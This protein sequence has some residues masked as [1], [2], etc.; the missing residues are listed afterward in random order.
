MFRKTQLQSECEAA[1]FKKQLAHLISCGGFTQ[2]NFGFSIQ[3]NRE[4]THYVGGF[5]KRFIEEN[6]KR[7]TVYITKMTYKVL[8]YEATITKGHKFQGGDY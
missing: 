4:I 2:V 5:L 8:K 7:I 6:N 3:H 1:A